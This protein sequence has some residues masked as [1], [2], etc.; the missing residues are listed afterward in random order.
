MQE[1]YYIY[2]L[3]YMH[4][5]LCIVI[6]ALY[7]I[8]CIWCIVL[9]CILY[10]ALYSIHYTIFNQILFYCLLPFH[11]TLW[12]FNLCKHFQ[13]FVWL[14]LFIEGPATYLN[15]LQKKMYLNL[16]FIRLTKVKHSFVSL[17]LQPFGQ[18]SDLKLHK[19]KGW[20][21]P[22]ISGLP[23]Q[24]PID[25]MV[26]K[27]LLKTLFKSCITHLSLW[28][29]QFDFE[30]KWVGQITILFHMGWRINQFE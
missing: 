3:Y 6:Y 20:R 22:K 18:C 12:L 5:I 9:S 30:I 4:C 26:L 21:Y 14:K 8:H 10:Y 25:I 1:S 24:L 13:Y 23:K 15:L 16:H 27:K 28:A 11:K 29:A 2:A 17:N 7:S 19:C